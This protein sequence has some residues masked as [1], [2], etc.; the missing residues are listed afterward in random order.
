[1]FSLKSSLTDTKLPI[2]FS[3]SEN[4]TL[5]SSKGDKK[6]ERRSRVVYFYIGVCMCCMGVCHVWVGAHAGQ[7]E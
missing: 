5:I 4:H 2:Y 7:K 1:L 6:E 3:S